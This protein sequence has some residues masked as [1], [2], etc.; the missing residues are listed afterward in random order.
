MPAIGPDA[1]TVRCDSKAISQLSKYT[2]LS[3]LP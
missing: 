2:L 1:Y 3:P